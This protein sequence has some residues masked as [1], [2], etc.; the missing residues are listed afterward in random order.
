LLPLA[1]HLSEKLNAFADDRNLFYAEEKGG[2]Y[3]FSNESLELGT[4]YRLLARGM[5]EPP[6]D[7]GIALDWKA[8][9]KVGDWRSYEMALPLAFDASRPQLSAQIEEFLGRCIRSVRP[10][11]FVVHPLPHHIE[12]DGT[13][14]YPE[15]PEAILLCRSANGNVTVRTSVG[16]AAVEV[17]EIA[18][19]WVELKG[20]PIGD[21]DCTVSIDGNEQVVFRTEACV[22]FRPPGLV[23]TAGDTIW[24]L[25][26]EVPIA[27]AELLHS[28]VQVECAN[29][30]VATHIA[31]Q[32]TDW[33]Q[34]GAALFSASGAAKKLRA[35]SFGELL[36]AV[37]VSPAQ[38]NLSQTRPPVASRLWVESLVAKRFGGEGLERVRRYF[39][40]PCRINL[41]RLGRIMTSS[42]MPYIRAVQ[43]QEWRD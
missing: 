38:K 12:S 5:I 43:K 3:V 14:V 34:E 42:L 11:L 31:R 39:S 37:F 29:V 33:R 4:R 16:S 17:S 35:G 21:Q 13:H 23:V 18:D 10:R 30:R 8:G 7:L 27:P 6:I 1:A 41:Y 26:A 40:N 36:G 20:L 22:L 28:D 32:N 25:L 19:E 24:D 15:T 9:Q 2:R